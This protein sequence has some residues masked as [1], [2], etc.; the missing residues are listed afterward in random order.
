M[1]ILGIRIPNAVQK[2]VVTWER[3]TAPYCL[4]KRFTNSIF[5]RFTLLNSLTIQSA[6]RKNN[7]PEI[8]EL[9]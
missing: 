7:I 4:L 2:E 5:T 9:Y 1:R 6:V 3:V 8:L